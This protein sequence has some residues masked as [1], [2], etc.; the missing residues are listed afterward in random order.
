MWCASNASGE[1]SSVGR[2]F[3]RNG[4]LSQNP[5]GR[6]M[7]A[8]RRSRRARTRRGMPTFEWILVLPLLAIGIIGGLAAIRNT[9]ICQFADVAEGIGAVE[10][11]QCLEGPSSCPLVGET[12]VESA[13][14]TPSES[15]QSASSTGN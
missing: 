6:P 9:I 12:T 3:T 1:E 7:K 13:W 2:G 5:T 11:C 4:P 10:V 8:N 14:W 15:Q